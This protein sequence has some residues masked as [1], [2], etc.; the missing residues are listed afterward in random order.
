MYGQHVSQRLRFSKLVCWERIS[1]EQMCRM[2]MSVYRPRAMKQQRPSYPNKPN[3]DVGHFPGVRCT[4][5]YNLSVT[6]NTKKK[7]D[8]QHLRQSCK[9]TEHENKPS[10]GRGHNQMSARTL[11]T[12]MWGRS[13]V[14]LMKRLHNLSIN[15][16]AR[17]ILYISTSGGCCVF[18]LN[19]LVIFLHRWVW[20]QK[21]WRI[22][23]TIM[24]DTRD[25]L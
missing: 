11:L 16:D 1:G 4:C 22:L 8:V 12:Q 3:I 18:E 24:A 10:K 25:K 15:D 20:K 6:G 17:N 21:P 5:Y 7:S 9:R 19:T 2:L 23:P 13:H 14:C